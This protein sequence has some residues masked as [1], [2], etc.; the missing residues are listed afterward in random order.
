[1]SLSVRHVPNALTVGRLAALPLIVWLYSRDA[2]G[3]S[4]ATA[5][6]ILVAALSDVADGVVARRYHAQSEFGLWMDPV[7]D[8]A[9]FF[10]IVAMLWYFGTLPW[11][12]AAPL[13]VRDGIILV[14]ALP[15]K[16]RTSAKPRI[17]G[18]SKV[19]NFILMC[20]LQW[21]IVDIRVLGWAFYAVGA[22]LYVASGLYYGYQVVEWLRG[23]RAGGSGGCAA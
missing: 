7:V 18:W 3:A 4:W 5:T 20:A 15:T 21:F 6:V 10:T 2:P 17:V 14:L 16:L 8:R 11:L 1:M 19:G 23:A 22:T 9:F 13:V 12:A